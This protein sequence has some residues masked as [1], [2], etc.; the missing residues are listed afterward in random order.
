MRRRRRHPPPDAAPNAGAIFGPERVA[1][2]ISEYFAEH[3]A[4]EVTYREPDLQSVDKSNSVTVLNPV[5]LAERV[6]VDGAQPE[7]VA[8]SKHHSVALALGFAF[9]VAQPPTEH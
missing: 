3:R 8:I 5:G 7:P 2:A 1:L 9:V 4:F 6:A